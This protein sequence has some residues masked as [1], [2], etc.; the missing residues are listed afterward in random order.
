MTCN[1]IQEQQSRLWKGTNK[2]DRFWEPQE[3]QLSA[4]AIYADRWATLRS[5]VH[6]YK[7][8]DQ[9]SHVDK[10]QG[11]AIIGQQQIM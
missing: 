1:Q 9:W 8:E 10:I 2:G 4:S 5:N 6:N 11:M 3:V 7:G